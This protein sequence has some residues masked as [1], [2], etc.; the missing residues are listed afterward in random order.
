MTSDIVVHI[1]HKLA[2]VKNVS[3]NVSDT[4]PRTSS[5]MEN[6]DANVAEN[7]N[8][9]N[10]G[11]LSEASR[12]STFRRNCF[13]FRLRRLLRRFLRRRK[14]ERERKRWR[15]HERVLYINDFYSSKRERER[16]ERLKRE[17]DDDD[18]ANKKRNFDHNKKT[19]H[20][21]RPAVEAE[22]RARRDDAFEKHAQHLLAFVCVCVCDFVDVKRLLF[23]ILYKNRERATFRQRNKKT[24]I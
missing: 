14:R 7:R 19:A 9:T 12:Q 16:G 15:H 2:T 22:K 6:E 5:T 1:A 4:S 13:V 23:W 24:H 20:R 3:V 21:I 8:A 17:R 10:A 18:D 11:T